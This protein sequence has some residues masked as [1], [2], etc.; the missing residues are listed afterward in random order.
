MPQMPRKPAEIAIMPRHL[1]S[2]ILVILL[3]TGGVLIGGRLATT[4]LAGQ[5]DAYQA[6][7]VFSQVLHR[8]QQDYVEDISPGT[9]VEGAINGMLRKLDPYSQ[10]MTPEQY[11]QFQQETSGDYFGIGVEIT[12]E[13]DGLRVV[14]P[15]PGSPAEKAGIEPNDLIISVDTVPI[16]EIGPTEAIGRIKGR[17]NTIVILGVEREGW[18]YA[19]DIDVKRD[20]IHTPAVIPALIEGGYGYIKLVQFQ[21]RIAN[22]VAEA[23]KDLERENRGKLNGL[24]LDM[25]NNPG[26]LLEEAIKL[27]D[28]FIDQG[29]IVKTEGRREEPEVEH[30]RKGGSLEDYPLTVL[31]N[32]GSASASEIV[33]G[34]LQDHDRAIIVGQRSYGKGSVQNIIRLDNEGALRL[35]VAKYYTPSGRPIEPQ[36]SITPDVLVELEDDVFAQVSSSTLR[37]QGPNLELDLQLKEALNQLINPGSEPISEPN[38]EPGPH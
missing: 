17:K 9:L 22:E 18:E 38:A 31:V 20:Q 28:L 3:T 32:R 2:F 11:R 27:S 35:T 37:D 5:Q 1:K 15:Y 8:I 19:K 16:L 30:A 29:I 23:V 26:G 7:E 25:R 21:D 34:A 12:S 13:T 24:I 14:S 36:N 6:L 10:Y 33:A 4:A